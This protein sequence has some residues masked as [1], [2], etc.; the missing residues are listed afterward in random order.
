MHIRR[1]PFIKRLHRFR[2]QNVL[3]TTNISVA[4]RQFIANQGLHS[5]EIRY[6]R[7][8]ES[9]L[10]I[11]EVAVEQTASSGTLGGRPTVEQQASMGTLNHLPRANLSAYLPEGM[12]KVR[13]TE[14]IQNR[15]S[16]EMSSVMYA[17]VS[18]KQKRGH[19][20]ILRPQGGRPGIRSI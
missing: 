18:R 9:A 20:H 7:S 1:D 12:S 15:V 17:C 4:Q 16:H 13:I 10:L 3:T 6:V 8:E 19:R 11:Y 2:I 14:Q 5:R